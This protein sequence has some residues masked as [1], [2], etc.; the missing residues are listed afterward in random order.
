VDELIQTFGAQ[1]G[2]AVQ[3]QLLLEE[4]AGK[5]RIEADLALARSI[6]QQLLPARAPTVPGFDL[7]GWNR[8]ADQTGGDFFDFQVL[9]SGAL[10]ITLA[11]VTGHGIGPA[12]LAAECRALLRSSL[13]LTPDLERVV[14]LVNRLLAADIPEDRFVT[15]FIGLLEPAAACCAYISA[16]QGPLVFYSAAD[17]TVTELPTTGLPLGVLIRTTYPLGDPIHFLPGDLLLLCSDGV[18][19]WM[20]PQRESFGNERLHEQVRQLQHLPPADLI[21]QIHHAVL[22]FARG[23]PQ[24]DDLTIVV[25]KKM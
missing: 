24:Q 8:P 15:A 17:G 12:L 21:R 1:A 16:G 4:F 3:R 23:T 11:D 5:Q 25:I 2:V 18:V 6:Q 14:S 22:D 20:D 10:A 7:A 9:D 13:A 19:E